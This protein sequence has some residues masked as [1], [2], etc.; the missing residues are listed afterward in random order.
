[1][2]CG[3]IPDAIE[4]RDSRVMCAM[5]VPFDAASSDGKESKTA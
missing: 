5:D 4:V 3:S 1:M 2:Q